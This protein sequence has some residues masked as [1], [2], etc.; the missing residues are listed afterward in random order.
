MIKISKYNTIERLLLSCNIMPD[1]HF[2][3]LEPP[4]HRM[5]RLLP[6]YFKYVQVY[7]WFITFVLHVSKDGTNILYS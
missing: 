1:E 3:D 4:A 5:L 6:L 7:L 2:I